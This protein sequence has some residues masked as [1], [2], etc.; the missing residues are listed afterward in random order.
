MKRIVLTG[1]GSLV[2]GM[3]KV[4]QVETGIRTYVAEDAE[5]CVALGTGKALD[6][7]GILQSYNAT[8]RRKN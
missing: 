1:G 3:D 6:N 5:S 4:I 7:I 8:T 2:Y